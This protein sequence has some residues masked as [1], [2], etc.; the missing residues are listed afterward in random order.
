MKKFDQL[1]NLLIQQLNNSQKR[2]LKRNKPSLLENED[3]LN[4]ECADAGLTTNAVFGSGNTSTNSLMNNVQKTEN[5]PGVSIA[6]VKEMYV[7]SLNGVIP[8][9][10]RRKKKK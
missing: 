6:N 7:P 5:S 3:E 4:N 8:P 1:Y 2:Q 10:Y 9:V